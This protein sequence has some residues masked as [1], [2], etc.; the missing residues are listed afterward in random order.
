MIYTLQTKNVEHRQS[1]L[2][3]L[4]GKKFLWRYEDEW[5]AEEIEKE[6][7]F[8]NNPILVMDLSEKY[9]NVCRRVIKGHEITIVELYN[10]IK[11]M[12]GK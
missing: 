11:E 2:K 10:K 8:E 5:T 7:P 12:E 9:L 1:I 3:Y 6:Y 4:L